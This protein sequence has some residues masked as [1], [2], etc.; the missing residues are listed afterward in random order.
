MNTMKA[1]IAALTAALVC[2]LLVSCSSD[3]PKGSDRAEPQFTIGVT[4]LTEEHP[5]YREL[6]GALIDQCEIRGLKPIIMSCNMDLPI[7]TS[8]IENFITRGVDAMVVCPAKSGGIAG[9]IRSANKAGI[10]VF[11]ADIA[12]QGGEVVSHIASD[13]VEGG[14][15]A[16]E[17]MA[18]L[19]NGKGRIAIVDCPDVQSVQDRVRGFRKAIK[20][21]PGIV[22]VDSPSAEGRRD[23][24]VTVT[25]NL[26]QKN[27]KLDGIFAINDNSALG[28]LAAIENAGRKEIVLIGYDGD[29]EARKKI[30]AGSPLKADAVQYPREIG[31]TTADAVADHLTGKKVPP[32]ISVRVGIIDRESLQNERE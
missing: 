27:A 7:Q 20:K 11:T 28:A 21:Y 18:K 19:L 25:E 32:V 23:V 3:K 17:Y 15:L 14:R 6:R 5:F 10:P 9:A 16:G 31:R 8:Q 30:L 1:I 26:L 22:I 12:A 24:A 4:L 29:P 2:A 13:N